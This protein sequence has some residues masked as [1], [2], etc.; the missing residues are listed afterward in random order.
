MPYEKQLTDDY[1]G[2]IH[3]GSGVVTG[4][5]ILEGCKAV[6]TLVQSTANFH[7]K[8]VDLSRATELRISSQEFEDI[9]EQDR[10][11][12]EQRPND[13]VAVVAPNENIRAIA[14]E[15]RRRAEGLG[16]A[17]EILQRKEEAMSWI[18]E[19]LESAQV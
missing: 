13:T 3:V 1:M 12:A 5:E 15:W 4:A 8:L 14:E 2:T 17:I 16:W 7:Y 6:T 10:L 11:I 19:R 9:L 18:Q